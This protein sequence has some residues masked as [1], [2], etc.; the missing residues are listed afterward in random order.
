MTTKGGFSLLAYPAAV[1]ALAMI[2]AIAL[3]PLAQARITSL[4][5][6]TSQP[7]GTQYF[8]S[9]GQ[10]EE[11]DGTATGE[12]DPR[13]PLNTIITDLEKAPQSHGKVQYS[14]TLSILKP[15]DL[16]KSNHTLFYDM[17]NRGN[18]VITGWNIGVT[19]SKPQGDG[20]LEDQGFIMAWSGW[21]GDLL[22]APGRIQLNA[23]VAKNYDGSSITG[24]IVTEYDLT[25]ATTAVHSPAATAA[26]IRQSASTTNR[27]H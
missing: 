17:V 24:R 13:D 1:S 14:F 18:K 26:I 21:E 27:Q 12:L 6:T 15:V 2:S 16:S 22:T 7:Y 10:Y 23:P 5:Y 9:V 4:S 8:G 25:T 19:T 11:L 20:F 3:A